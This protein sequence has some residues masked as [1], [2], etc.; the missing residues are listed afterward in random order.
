MNSPSNN[1]RIQ[2][3]HHP[4]ALPSETKDAPARLFFGGTFD[5]PHLAHTQLPI[6]AAQQYELTHALMPGQCHLVYVP[7]SRSPHKDTAPTPDQHRV[8]ML[9]IAIK[10]LDHPATVWTQELA[11][12]LLNEGQPSYWADTWAIAHSMLTTGTNRFLIGADQ[13]RSMHKWHR[14]QEFW[15]DAIVILRAPPN[16]SPHQSTNQSTDA[17]ND[18]TQLIDQLDQTGAWTNEDLRHW[19]SICVQTQ[20]LPYA[21]TTI[22]EQLA[23]ANRDSR[24]NNSP[25]NSPDN[26]PVENQQKTTRIEGLDPGVQSYIFKH[27]LYS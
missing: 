9:R 19:E 16:Q 4:V 2:R 22:R 20:T 3:P 10:D 8:E 23:A 15:K 25:D 6:L 14:Y 21:S 5:P 7:A 11:D 26:S 27:Q 18:I 1:N 17:S 12:G 13:A 24:P